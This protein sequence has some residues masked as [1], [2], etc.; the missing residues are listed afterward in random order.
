MKKRI[1]T[2]LRAPFLPAAGGIGGIPGIPIP[3]IIIPGKLGGIAPGG[4]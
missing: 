1:E 3:G 2:H 4:G